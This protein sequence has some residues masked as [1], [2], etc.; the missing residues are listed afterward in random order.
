VNK[1]KEPHEWRIC[2]L[3][4]HWVVTHP[5]KTKTGKITTRHSH[6]A[7][8]PSKKDQIYSDELE[9]IANKY[10]DSLSGPP[11]NKTLGYPQGNKFDKLIRGWCKY[12]ND[13]FGL[14]DTIDPNLVKALIATESGFRSG[15]RIKDGTGQGHAT[16]LMQ[17]TYATQKILCDENGE[18]KDHLVNIDQKELRDPNLNIAAG[19]RWL[20]RKKEIASSR[21]GREASWI[22]TIMLY[23]G[24]KNINNR[25]MKKLLNLYKKFKDE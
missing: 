1:M 19:I 23:K 6:C 10:F 3:G 16:G 24:Y 25:Q 8:N 4:E 7:K 2:P 12:W 9:Y 20:F 17:V 21:F 18:L 5:M 22:E 15:I 13:I 11:S 14:K